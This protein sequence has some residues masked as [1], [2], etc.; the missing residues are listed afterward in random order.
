MRVYGLSTFQ[1]CN[2]LFAVVVALYLVSLDT[3][4]PGLSRTVTEIS[5]AQD[6]QKFQNAP[7]V[8][9]VRILWFWRDCI[10]VAIGK[11]KVS[12]EQILHSSVNKMRPTSVAC[13]IL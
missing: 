7:P 9:G 8:F 13:V 4:N 1:K 6:L 10:S 11:Q 3:E 2:S 5:N 12:Y